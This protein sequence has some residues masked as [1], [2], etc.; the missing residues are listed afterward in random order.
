MHPVYKGHI[1][2]VKPLS[3]RLI[4]KK[5]EL[6]DYVVCKG[7]PI[8]RHGNWP[9]FIIQLNFGFRQIKINCSASSSSFIQYICKVLHKSQLTQIIS[10]LFQNRKIRL[11][12]YPVQLVIGNGIIHIEYAFENLMV[13][14]I[15]H[16]VHFHHNGQSKP[17]AVFI[18]TA[19]AV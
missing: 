11:F 17:V 3:N 2:P 14:H 10:K 7:C 19:Y 15:A 9:S 6:L 8:C 1:V 4:A 5:H 18:Q 13:H 12:K 16:F